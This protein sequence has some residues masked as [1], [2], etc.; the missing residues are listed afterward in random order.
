MFPSPLFTR[1]CALKKNH[2]LAHEK[3]RSIYEG[4]ASTA[5]NRHLLH[6]PSIPHRLPLSLPIRLRRRLFSGQSS[7]P[8]PY[9]G[10][11]HT[12]AYSCEHPV[13]WRLRELMDLWHSTSRNRI[14]EGDV[15]KKNTL[16]VHKK[17]RYRGE[18]GK[19]IN[20]SI[21]LLYLG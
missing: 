2:C 16:V 17:D 4:R 8:Q 14:K 12:D 19:S 20:K 15:K 21:I 6:S 3:I 13:E 5:F 1:T 9:P 7:P 10:T 11:I 18:R